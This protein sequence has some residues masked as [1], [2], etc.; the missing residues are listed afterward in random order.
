MI[1][2]PVVFARILARSVLAVGAADESAH[3]LLFVVRSR[4][5]CAQSNARFSRPA[6]S[7]TNLLIVVSAMKSQLS[8]E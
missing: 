8:F 2:A 7:Q 5:E 3:L 4:E 6:V 1:Y